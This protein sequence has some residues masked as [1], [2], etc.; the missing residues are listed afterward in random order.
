MHDRLVTWR[1]DALH[2]CFLVIFCYKV[3]T[4]GSRDRRNPTDRHNCLYYTKAK[5]SDGVYLP[6]IG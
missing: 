2:Q 4:D 1:I 5:I 3:Y 6:S